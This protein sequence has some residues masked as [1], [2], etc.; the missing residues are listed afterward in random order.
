[1]D[2]KFVQALIASISTQRDQAF[3]ALAHCEAKI[4]MLEAELAELKK[5]EGPLANKVM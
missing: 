1:M 3:N 2:E 4:R 5:P